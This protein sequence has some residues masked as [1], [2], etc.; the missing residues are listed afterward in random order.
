MFPNSENPSKL[1]AKRQKTGHES[2]GKDYAEPPK[3]LL[4]LAIFLNS[5]KRDQNGREIGFGISRKAAEEIADWDTA[6]E[7]MT[8]NNQ[9]ENVLEIH[10]NISEHHP[11]TQLHSVLEGMELDVSTIQDLVSCLDRQD[12]LALYKK[13]KSLNY[14]TDTQKL[15]KNELGNQINFPTFTAAARSAAR[16]AKD[17]FGKF[18]DG[19]KQKINIYDSNTLQTLR[20]ITPDK[21]FLGALALV[22]VAA[23]FVEINNLGSQAKQKIGQIAQGNPGIERVV[24][25]GQE[26]GE[27]IQD[28]ITGE[29]TQNLLN[30][31]EQ[32]ASEIP[33]K[34]SD[35][36][37]KFKDQKMAKNIGDLVKRGEI[38]NVNP[39]SIINYF[40]RQLNQFGHAMPAKKVT[41]SKETVEYFG[42][43]VDLQKVIQQKIDL[44]QR[45]SDNSNNDAITRETE[46][47]IQKLR[48]YMNNQ[49]Y[50]EQD[51]S[52]L[53]NI[54]LY[55]PQNEL[56][57]ILPEVKI[58]SKDDYQA[59]PIPSTQPIV[60]APSVPTM[61]APVRGLGST[62]QDSR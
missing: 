45:L 35:F 51:P 25:K 1:E 30:P 53:L 49:K 2:E 10:E 56:K 3:R 42:G 55:N 61:T 31:V 33:Q 14:L 19:D 9:E 47:D 28:L 32:P 5:I 4:G 60:P 27:S 16:S 50:L 41:E 23:A 24:K 43:S 40:E 54:E 62:S 36:A 58:P 21:Y 34:D 57:N 26:L 22:T 48:N 52:T 7:I 46:G 15:L 8:S 37:T 13:F 39:E 18:V 11:L 12:K 44:I 29:P 6:L 20:E 17:G 38:S 59:Q